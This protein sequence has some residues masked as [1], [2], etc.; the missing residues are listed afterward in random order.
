M[1]D[2]TSI[3][4]GSGSKLITSIVDSGGVVVGTKIE[5]FAGVL[6]RDREFAN[7]LAK[8][9]DAELGVKGYISSDELP[10]YGISREEKTMIED[11]FQAG[12]E[13][14]VVFVADK[15]DKAE[16][17]IEIIEQEISQY[18]VQ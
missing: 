11:A 1:K 7:N 12:P 14:S 10:T 9:L 5:N 6:P 4:G 8:K 13:D 16:K 3:F 15:Q 17:A 18:K 2:I